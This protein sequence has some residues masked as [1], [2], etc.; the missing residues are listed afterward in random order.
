MTLSAVSED[1]YI[2]PL[3]FAQEHL[4][5]LQQANPESVAYNMTY[6]LRLQGN[7]NVS[8][9]ECAIQT[10]YTRHETLRTS[11][12]MVDGFAMQVISPAV[13]MSLPFID[14]S[15]LS[16]TDAMGEVKRLA[17]DQETTCFN[18]AQEVLIRVQLLRLAD[19][20][21]VLLLTLHHIIA[22]GWSIGIIIQE[23]STLYSAYFQGKPPALP[24]LPIQY[25][26]FSDWQRDWLSGPV[27]Q[28]L[29]TYWTSQLAGVPTLLELP[30]DRTYPAIRTAQGRTEKFVVDPTLALQLKTLAQRQQVTLF[31]LLLAAF[32]T[33]LFRYSEQQDMVIGT[34]IA[35]RTR[36]EFEPLIGFFVNTLALRLQFQEISTFQ[37]LLDQVRQVS[38][39]AYEHQDLPFAHV[40]EALDL[41]RSLSHSPLVQV[42]F[43]LQNASSEQ[44]ELP[45][46]T[47][48]SLEFEET[49]ARFDLTLSVQETAAGL[50][51]QWEYST[52]LFE[53]ETIRRMIV[54]F[55][56]L[57]EGIVDNP[58]ELLD[59][60]P[61]LPKPES[62]KLL[63]E[64]ND[65]AVDYPKER[66]IHQLFEAQV[67][68]TP[69]AVAVE[70]NTQQ[71]TY[72]VLNQRAN[73][74]ARYLQT[75]GVGPE[76]LVGICV[77]RSLDMIVGLL[78]ILKAGGGYVPM[79]PSYPKKRL[80]YMLQDS[81]ASVLLT[82]Q[83]IQESF[84][85]SGVHTICLDLDWPKIA[86][87]GSGNVE[88]TINSNNLAYVIYT[89]GS[90]GK[91][92][93]VEV[94]HQGLTN[95]LCWCVQHYD[96]A[97]GSGALVHTPLGFDA[98]IT[99]LFSPLLVGRTVFLL[100]EDQGISALAGA[101]QQGNN[102]SLVKLTPAHLKL[103]SSLIPAEKLAQQ[104]HVFVIGGEA[105][106]KDMISPWLTHAPNTRLINE[107]GPTE[108]VVGCCI[109]EANAHKA[110][111]DLIP[112]GRPIAN[113]Q[114]YILDSRLHPLPIGAVGE[115]YIGGDGVARGYRGLPELSAEKFMANPF[116]LG[117]LY[118]TGDLARYLPDGNVEFLGRIDN[119]VKLRGFRIELGEIEAVLSAHPHIQQ[120][121][122]IVREDHPEDKR[123][124]A[125]VV[126]QHIQLSSIEL[127]DFLKAQLP[128]Y[129][130]PNTFMQLDALPLTPNGKVDR[131]ALPSPESLS[132]PSR[133]STPPRNQ[134]EL[135]LARI[136][137]DVLKVDQIGMEDD[138]F[139]LGGHS[140]IA[141]ALMARIKEMLGYTLPFNTLFQEATIEQQA[142]LLEQ[143]VDPQAW[144]PLTPL[145]PQGS[146]PPL[147][148]IHPGG[149][150]V[151]CYQRLM[152]YLGQQRAL[153]GLETRGFIPGQSPRTSIEAMATDYI[154]SIQVLQPTGPYH[155]AGWCLGGMIAWEVAQQLMI[156]GQHVS[157][158]I[159][160]D[161]NSSMAGDQIPEPT[162]LLAG[163]VGQAL[164][165]SAVDL[166]VLTKH[167]QS[168]NWE[169]QLAYVIS[170]A[171]HR[172]FPLSPGFGMAQLDS[173]VQIRRGHIQ[174]AQSYVP[175]PY[176]GEVVL[177]QAEGGVAAR[178]DDPTLGWQALAQKTTLHWVPGNH[179]SMMRE[180][181]VKVLGQ[182]FKKY[183]D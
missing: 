183:L 178:A 128:D 135:K 57:L 1:V 96:I 73:Q 154:Q 67:E 5:F 145:Q 115:L 105:L 61:L 91:P 136:W 24:E 101:L 149:G 59:Q 30:S 153:Y 78:G 80:I 43:L 106:M 124:V 32:G 46:L 16:S 126:N 168:M 167:L 7:L 37:D 95:Y 82:Q 152:P 8:A 29:L 76:I 4:W 52:D 17:I 70:F 45:G 21:H 158:L 176:P 13:A 35:N 44:L 172:N 6:A 111:A 2:Y 110:L 86:D 113:T 120:V 64:W 72:E 3:S 26:D 155:L 14:L 93:G 98:T 56:T 23:T 99:G 162:D 81:A 166:E 150:S 69:K 25:G 31:M 63:K 34:S 132:G 12:E 116:G 68:K 164:D 38:L 134:M 100:P 119:S 83:K 53:A 175:K 174:A 42:M 181:H 90:T 94:I 51:G 89:S 127:R 84:S 112:I 108:T 60:L 66:C 182:Y 40:V 180:P 87:H 169:D 148:L 114:L 160:I 131:N 103:L 19:T 74:L 15:T 58:Q 65:T 117:R 159:F 121:S 92:K 123:L 11:I 171:E 144:T 102:F 104:A 62:Q 85:Q 77:E 122:V 130:L 107:Y 55:H 147:F 179:L 41:E 48:S 173:I 22:D 88:S 10:I 36:P 140:L 47:L 177:L 133:V 118:R 146:H 165:L 109:Y 157:R 139:E 79:D 75:V 71:L 161:V 137:S 49:R 97:R 27:L 39:G 129:M 142:M 9:L 170:E 18:L 143:N 20:D 50:Q 156:Q 151:L 163:M 28:K 54:H 125:Y 138:F 141:L 33:L